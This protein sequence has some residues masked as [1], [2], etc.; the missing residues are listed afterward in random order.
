MKTKVVFETTDAL[1]HLEN[2]IFAL[3]RIE[4]QGPSKEIVQLN[5]PQ[6]VDIFPVIQE[7]QIVDSAFNCKGD[8]LCLPY[9]FWFVINDR[10]R[11][12][13]EEFKRVP[14]SEYLE[15]LDAQEMIL[16]SLKEEKQKEADKMALSILSNELSAGKN[17]GS[18]FNRVKN[19]AKNLFGHYQ[20][21]KDAYDE[22][23]QKLIEDGFGVIAKL[24]TELEKENGANHPKDKNN[25]KKLK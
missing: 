16:P 18:F 10:I 11:E 7:I 23:D 25:P 19:A 22:K 5:K 15:I 20:E 13:L 3:I 12:I 24:L 9:K 4:Y 17:K 6:N 1:V 2:D 14:A 8:L 21:N